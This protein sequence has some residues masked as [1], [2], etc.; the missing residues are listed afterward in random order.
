MEAEVAD[1]EAEDGADWLD[2]VVLRSGGRIATDGLL[3]RIGVDATFP[4]IAGLTLNQ[5]FLPATI[6]PQI[7][8]VG[9][10]VCP[11][12]RA[13]PVAIGQGAAAARLAARCL[14]LR[15]G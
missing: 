10:C 4:E 7:V 1:V 15:S 13:V 2:A 12:F 11:D 3:V 6:H 9:D 14:G 5:G 8:A